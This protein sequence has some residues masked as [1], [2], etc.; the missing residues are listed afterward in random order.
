MDKYDIAKLAESLNKTVRQRK[1][2]TLKRWG[3][4]YCECGHELET[5]LSTDGH[6]AIRI[7]PKCEDEANERD[8]YANDDEQ[9]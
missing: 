9:D 2:A 3:Q 8:H 7:C 4:K 6:H 1:L 5:Y